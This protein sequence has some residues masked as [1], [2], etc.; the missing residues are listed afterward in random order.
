VSAPLET[1]LAAS[2]PSTARTLRDLCSALP[3]FAL[4]CA[5]LLAWV[6]P[7]SL[8]AGVVPGILLTMLVEFI[9]VHSAPFMGL[10][11]V[12]E[13]PAARKV[14]N[15]VVI[16]L[17]YSM[18]LMGFSI[19]FHAWWPFL[20]FWFLTANRLTV[21]VFSQ[22]DSGR[23][24]ETLKASWAAGAICYLTGA[25]LTTMLPIPRLGLTPQFVSSLGLSGG[26]L[27]I[28]QPWRVMAFA[29]FYFAASGMLEAT[30]FTMLLPKR[31]PTR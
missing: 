16:G 7:E 1:T 8:N 4:A 25:G 30:G 24:R 9:V 6:A 13:Q 14:R 29:A 22:A 10:Q 20:S 3:D 21:L 5:C 15:V 2:S 12:S 17:F 11:V 27:W 26:G 23:E 18:F 31:A 28:E 19:A